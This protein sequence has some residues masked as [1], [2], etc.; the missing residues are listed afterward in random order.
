MTIWLPLVEGLQRRGL[1]RQRGDERPRRLDGLRI[2][3]VED[4]ED[5]REAMRLMLERLGADVLTARDGV[6]ALETVMS[7]RVDL[8]VC[9]LRMPRMDGFEFLHAL[10][11]GG[12][13]TSP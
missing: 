2:L 12:T 3:V 11:A 8:V 1:H 6:E 4:V 5:S 7:E 9:D 10:R 13:R